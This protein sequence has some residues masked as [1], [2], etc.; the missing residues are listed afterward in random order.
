MTHSHIPTKSEIDDSH[1]HEK[2]GDID[3]DHVD[4]EDADDD[5][6]GN[7]DGDG[8]VEL[9]TNQTSSFPQIETRSSWKNRPVLK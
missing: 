2:K 4:D 1:D 3:D 8:D 9:F 7:I 5:G 6:D